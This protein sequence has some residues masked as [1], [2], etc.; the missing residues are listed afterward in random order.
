VLKTIGSAEVDAISVEPDG[1][2]RSDNDKF[3]TAQPKSVVPSRAGSVKPDISG[4]NSLEG[5][6]AL[7]GKGKGKALVTEALT[8]DSDDDDDMPLAKRPRLNGAGGGFRTSLG[9]TLSIDSSPAP[10]GAGGG[11]GGAPPPPRRM[12]TIDLT[13]SDSDDEAPT[14]AARPPPAAH[15]AYVPPPPVPRPASAASSSNG[16]AGYGASDFQAQEALR[17]QLAEQAQRRQ[18]DDIRR[19][20]EEQA[21]ANGN[22][23]GA[24]RPS[25]E[26]GSLTDEWREEQRE[27]R[28][29]EL[30]S[31]LWDSLRR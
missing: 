8:L 29:R 31:D 30:T 23:N 4:L 12:D 7:E 16:A 9:G 15:S 2:W 26:G 14:P 24:G 10:N 1:T 6:T 21:R 13:L 17:K 28:V 27:E 11:G 22:G 5:S 3:G 18:L 25:W 20:R 19:R